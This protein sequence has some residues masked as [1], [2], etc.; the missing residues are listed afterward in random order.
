MSLP[1]AT[2]TRA[3]ERSATDPPRSVLGAARGS[4]IGAGPQRRH[5]GHMVTQR[6][7]VKSPSRS[8]AKMAYAGAAS[9]QELGLIVDSLEIRPHRLLHRPILA[10]RRLP[11][12]TK[13]IREESGHTAG[14]RP[15]Q[16]HRDERTGRASQ[17]GYRVCKQ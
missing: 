17:L 6:L 9:P 11:D 14:T 15:T 10:L 13:Q 7:E 2:N 5:V 8:E 3:W 16:V 12:R 1:D 4:Q